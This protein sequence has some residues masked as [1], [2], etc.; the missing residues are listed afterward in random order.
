MYTPFSQKNA[1]MSGRGHELAI[2]HLYP[3]LFGVTPQQLTFD[4]ATLLAESERGRVLDGEMA[5]DYIARLTIHPL[6][7]PL[8]VTVQER[9]RQHRYS[10][11][12]DVTLTEWNHDSGLPSELYKITAG[13]FLYGYLNESQ[14]G[15][16]E[17]IAFNVADF[18][19]ALSSGKLA[20]RRKEHNFRSNQSFLCFTFQ[21]LFDAGIVMFHFTPQRYQQLSLAAD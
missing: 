11:F 7:A 13:I 21:Q 6:G 18:L 2:T 4:D 14:D 10:A 12:R 19:V 17:A 8:Q 9:F 15:F 5:V 3:N 20:I 16:T 1:D